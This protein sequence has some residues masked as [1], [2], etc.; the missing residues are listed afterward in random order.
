VEVVTVRKDAVDHGLIVGFWYPALGQRPCAAGLAGNA[1]DQCDR[2][3][4]VVQVEDRVR[5]ANWGGPLH[6]RYRPHLVHR[7]PGHGAGVGEQVECAGGDDVEL[8]AAV[9]FVC[10]DL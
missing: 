1:A 6:T 7:G 3:L 5:G 8:G 4:A 2:D 10:R 9:V